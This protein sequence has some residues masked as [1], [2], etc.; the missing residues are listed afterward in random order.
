MS[1]LERIAKAIYEAYTVGSPS[2]HEP[3]NK[4]TQSEK[5][6]ATEMAKAAVGALVH[7]LMFVE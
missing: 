1:R 2:P 4:L 6:L 7:D 5:A 3:W